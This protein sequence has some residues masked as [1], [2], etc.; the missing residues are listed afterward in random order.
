MTENSLNNDYLD[1]ALKA[2]D[3]CRKVLEQVGETCCTYE[4]SPQIERAFEELQ[5]A[6]TALMGSRAY[7]EQL[8][9]CAASITECGSRIGRLQVSCCTEIRDPLYRQILQG[10][11]KA[12]E[13][14][15][16][17][18]GPGD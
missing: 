1:G 8:S 2:L 17:A 10:L 4:R 15:D 18:M 9:V 16:R 6:R 5:K 3:H 13:H 7:P 14:L 11:N 12:Q